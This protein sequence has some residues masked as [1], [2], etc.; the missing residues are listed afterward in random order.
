ML[1]VGAAA[2][3]VG[4][5]ARKAIGSYFKNKFTDHVQFAA[6]KMTEGGLSLCRNFGKAASGFK[7]FWTT[8]D[9]L[10]KI[11][12]GA[13]SLRKKE[14][15]TQF[16]DNVSQSNFI[17]GA[18]KNVM[19]VLGMGAAIAV[20]IATADVMI[21]NAEAFGQA[22]GISDE[23]MA[24][25]VGVGTNAPEAATAAALVKRGQVEEALAGT[26]T[27]NAV[28]VVGAGGVAAAL[29]TDG[30]PDNLS[31][32]L[33]SASSAKD[34][35]LIAGAPA[36]ATAGAAVTI[37]AGEKARAPAAATTVVSTGGLAAGAIY[38]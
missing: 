5:A 24:G 9:P 13:T 37:H 8:G 3:L 29:S 25:A 27:S 17:E 6:Q 19:S 4:I 16:F 33:G 11:Y 18:K 30:L 35:A 2:T 38:L 36:V 31:D 32:P 7:R 34:F 26:I 21:E 14:T 23:V 28:N 12:K 20:L 10:Q 1:A 22:T 15:Y